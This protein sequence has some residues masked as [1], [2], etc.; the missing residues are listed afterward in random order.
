MT[1]KLSTGALVVGVIGICL[2]FLDH[3][4][5]DSLIIGGAILVSAS[6]I[7][8]AISEGRRRGP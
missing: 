4:H 8:T 7:A 2:A 6:V 3:V 5:G 1:E